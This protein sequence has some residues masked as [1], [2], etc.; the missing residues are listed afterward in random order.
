MRSD[1]PPPKDPRFPG[2]GL[3]GRLF[4]P[5]N[6]RR[7]SKPTKIRRAA[8]L[9]FALLFVIAGWATSGAWLG[10]VFKATGS[11]LPVVSPPSFRMEA[12][13][14]EDPPRS[15]PRFSIARQRASTID[16]SAPPRLVEW[17]A[18]LASG[19]FRR[20]GSEPENSDAAG[21]LRVEYS[22]GETLT[23]E[24]FH[25]LESGRVERGLAIVLDPRSGRLLAYVST[26]P[27]ALSP[28]GTYPAA[29]IVKLLTA[30]TLLEEAP[31][32]AEQACLYRGNKYRLSR[33]RLVRPKSGF[34]TTLARALAS[35]NNQCFAQWA[36]HVL[37]EQKLRSAFQNFGWLDSPAPGHEPGR[38]G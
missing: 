38:L 19:A 26:D 11:P 21:V 30:A 23:E 7:S 9:V 8:A 18:P 16:P 3:L 15:E 25:I 28:D 33:S 31:V 17:L 37:G 12:A 14:I 27:E 20:T 22:L 13:W 34:R 6:R 29:S 32:E 4:P 24:I 1:S 35:S 5:R 10:E 2:R 36:V